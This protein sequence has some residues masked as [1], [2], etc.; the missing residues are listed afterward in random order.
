MLLRA[1]MAMLAATAVT[2]GLLSAPGAAPATA[3]GSGD[4]AIVT[5]LVRSAIVPVA[6]DA[7]AS[8]GEARGSR[9]SAPAR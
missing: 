4:D 6:V 8:T 2:L 9:G 7:A 1:M 3:S 5:C